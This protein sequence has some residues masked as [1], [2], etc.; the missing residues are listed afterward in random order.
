MDISVASI[1]NGAGV[2]IFAPASLCK[3]ECIWKKDS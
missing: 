3:C 2:N 1:T